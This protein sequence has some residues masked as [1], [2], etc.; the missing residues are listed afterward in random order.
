MLKKEVAVGVF[1]GGF[2]E[3]FF[4]KSLDKTFKS[5]ILNKK[6]YVLPYKYNSL[7]KSSNKIKKRGHLFALFESFA[8][9][10]TKVDVV[11]LTPEL[12]LHL[13]NGKK[14]VATTTK[15]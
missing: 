7:T 6:E 5:E 8:T 14:I 12:F 9:H 3:V 4:Y 13:L 10:C 15:H 1:V 2:C 11:I